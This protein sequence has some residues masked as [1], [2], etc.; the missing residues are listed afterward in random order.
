MRCFCVTTFLHV[1]HEKGAF[2]A[3]TSAQLLQS[4]ECPHG[5]KTTQAGASQQTMHRRSLTPSSW[6]ARSAL[7]TAWGNRVEGGR[8][9]GKRGRERLAHLLLRRARILTLTV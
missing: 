2:A 1:G 8:E 5:S 4:C 7:D 9:W 6:A 3:S